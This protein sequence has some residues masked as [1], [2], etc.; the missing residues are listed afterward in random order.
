LQE[1][2]EMHVGGGGYCGIAP[3]SATSANVTFVLDRARIRDA[4]GDLPG[5]YRRTLACWPRVAARLAAATLLEPPRAIGPLALV[6]RRL[7]VP[8]ALLVGDAAGFYD[9]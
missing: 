2:G 4:A 5:F 7:S 8:G 6:A 3:L 1:R 9:P